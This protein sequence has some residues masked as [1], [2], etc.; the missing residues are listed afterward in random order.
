MDDETADDTQLIIS[1]LVTN[2]VRYGSPPIELRLI[3]DR[4]LTCEV[5]DAGAAAEGGRDLFIA[6]RLAQAWGT[7]CTAPGKTIW[8]EPTLPPVP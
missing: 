2:A 1:E 4:T 7:R 8:A 6:A 5:R 3:H